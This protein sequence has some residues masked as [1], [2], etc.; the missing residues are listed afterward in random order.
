VTQDDVV[1]TLDVRTGKVTSGPFVYYPARAIS[2][3]G[4]LVA[5]AGKSGSGFAIRVARPDGGGARNVL[6]VPACT[7]DGGPVAAVAGLQFTPDSRSLVYQSYCVEPFANLYSIAPDGTAL[8]RL[9]NVQQQQTDPALSPDGTQLVYSWAPATGL[10]CKGCAENLALAT[11]DGATIRQLT[12]QEDGNFNTDPSFS[13]DGAGILYSHGTPNDIGLYVVPSAGG[14][15]SDLHISAQFAAWGP[16]RIA[17]TAWTGQQGL[18]TAK[19][20]GT[21]RALVASGDVYSPTWS[22]DGRLAWLETLRTGGVRLH[23]QGQAAHALPAFTSVAEIAWS[24][25]G[26]RFAAAARAKGTAAP[27]VYTFDLDGANVKRL[28]RDA[29]VLSLAYR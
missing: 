26:K 1:K 9:T 14:A 28:T 4:R 2:P 17:Y 11:A 10:S 3:D 8:R 13:P 16:T 18:W 6:A 7:D 21:D 23:V 20:D 24:P 22:S 19:P 29:G 25:D 12:A 5:R 15:P 27:D